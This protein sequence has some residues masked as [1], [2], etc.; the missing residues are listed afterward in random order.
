MNR[1][2]VRLHFIHALTFT[3]LLSS[4][5]FLYVTP[6]RT[7]FNEIHF[8]L[9]TPHYVSAC[10]YLLVI[11]YGSRRLL[12]YMKPRPL[13][14]K[15]NGGM[16]L[17]FAGLWIL[18]G[19]AMYVQSSLPVIVRNNAVIVHDWS[20]FLFIPWA[21]THSLGHFFQIRIPWPKWWRG[22]APIPDA[23]QENQLERRDFIKFFAIGLV[24]I[25]IGRY[26]KWLMPALSIST[27][28]NKRKGYFRIYNV[29]NDTPSYTEQEWSLTIDGA[30]NQTASL[31]LADVP[32]FTSTTLVDDFHC[33]TGWSVHGV[34]L[35]GILLKDLF[36]EMNLTTNASY[37]TAYSGDETYYDSFTVKQLLDE[38]AMLIFEM[39]GKPLKKAQGYPCRL[40]HPDMYGYK[41]V[42]WL[43]RLEFTNERERGYWQKS[44]GYDLDGYL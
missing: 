20:T 1:K 25:M 39:D 31:K 29:T 13:L 26:V 9:V 28:E 42:K 30:V 44:G 24:F 21:L 14:K 15:Y 12:H 2:N 7:W 36:K 32:R 10:I 18:S 43:N 4:G 22:K 27:D 19:I 8:P 5:L 11:L 41:S 34:E 6:T 23:I 35:K 38:G 16:L 37:I 40:Y 17:I 3:V 33:V